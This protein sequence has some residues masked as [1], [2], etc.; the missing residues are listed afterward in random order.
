MNSLADHFL[1]Q[2]DWCARLGSP[3]T[4]ALMQR[5][6]ADIEAGGIVAS[7]TSG[8]DANPKRDAVGLRLAGALHAAVLSGLDA[9]LAGAYPAPQ[10]AWDMDEVWPLAEAYLQKNADWVGA[11]LSSP[12]QTNEVGR[13]GALAPAFMWLASIAPQPFRMLE[14]GASAGL[15]M[16][17]DRFRYAHASWARHEGDGPLIQTVYE[18]APPSWGDID[19]A[20]RAACDVGPLDPGDDEAALRLQAY[21]W[22]DQFDRLAR[23]RAAIE[24][25]RRAPWRVEGADAADWLRSRLAGGLQPGT[26]VIYHSIFLQYPPAEVRAAIE[27]AIVEAGE[28]A[29]SDRQLAWVCF[30]PEA[31]LGGPPDSNRIVIRVRRWDGSGEQTVELGEGD[32]HGHRVTWRGAG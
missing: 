24:L 9:G 17:W 3:F 25:A 22:P 21:I 15:N 1:T 10:R 7:L 18:G 26:T 19:I 2:G 16:N 27:A 23:L 5:A 12:P 4:A 31:V 8:W 11:F 29:T 20:E 28:K 6:A 32:P 30:E 13:A 14:L